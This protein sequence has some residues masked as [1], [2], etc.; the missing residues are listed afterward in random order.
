[1]ITLEINLLL[2]IIKMARNWIKKVL[3]P[4]R[5]KRGAK[6]GGT[7]VFRRQAERNNMS[8]RA[9]VNKVKR[10][11]SKYSKLTRQRASLALT[12][13]RMKK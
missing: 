4:H 3:A 5:N 2:N 12:L 13:M 9:F 11:P 7:G 6:R 1:M 8:T 10:N